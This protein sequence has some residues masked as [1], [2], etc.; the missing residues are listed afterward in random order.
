MLPG[1][2]IEKLVIEPLEE[3]VS[4]QV[5]PSMRVFSSTPKVLIERLGEVPGLQPQS[6]RK[7]EELL[8]E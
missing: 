6:N 3:L 4:E 1:S 5:E 7:L 8:S 2:D